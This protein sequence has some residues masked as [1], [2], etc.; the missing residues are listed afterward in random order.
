MLASHIPPSHR[1]AIYML[2]VSFTQYTLIGTQA[3]RI[4]KRATVCNGSSD[5]CNRSYG[6]VTFAGA[7][8]SY[9]IGSS[10][11]ANQNVSITAQLDAGI[12]MLQAQAHNSTNATVTGAGIDLCHTS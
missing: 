9:A 2:L 10:V 4:P 5:L 8:D 11:A 7:H 1:F 12:R 3:L 6:N